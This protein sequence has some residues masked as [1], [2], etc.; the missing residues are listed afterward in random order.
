MK[1]VTLVGSPRKGRGN[2][3]A[4]VDLVGEGIGEEKGAQEVIFL[5]GSTVRPCKGCDTCHITGVCP[6]KDAFL[7]IKEK[8][9]AA[10]G[11]ILA[12]PN[13]ILH[14]SAQL[15]SFIDRCCGVVHLLEF[16]GKYGAAVVTSGGGDEEPIA[17]YLERFMAWTGVV[18]VGS[19]WATM[20][21]EHRVF[22][23]AVKADAID[24]GRRLVRAWREKKRFSGAEEEMKLFRERM[25]WLMENRKD[26]W[27]YE[28][29]YWKAHLGL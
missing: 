21:G 11:I 19:V 3:S 15:K 4:L 25:R 2:T 1:I 29:D 12:T 14:V 23:P 9:M 22:T 10:D 27:R 6:Q 26:L 13:Y 18:P 16:R 28:Y 20:G 7:A 8:I 5:P 17:R 24:L